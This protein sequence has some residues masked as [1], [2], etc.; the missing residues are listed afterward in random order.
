MDSGPIKV[1]PSILAGDFGHLAD[2]ARRIEDSGAD[3]LHIDIMDGNF[4]PNLTLG[5]KAITAINR[6][7]SMFLD[8]HIMVYHPFDNIER[9]VESGADNITFHFEATEDVEDTLHYIRKC[10]IKAG[11]AFRPETP[12]GM[13]LKYL[14]M[15]D[16]ILMMTVDPGFGG[17]QFIPDVLEKVREIR[18]ICNKLNIRE[19]GVTP[20]SGSK[21]EKLPPLD[22]QVDGGVN[23][24]T[25]RQAIEA[26]ANVLVAGSYLFNCSN[27]AEGIRQLRQAASTVPNEG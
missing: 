2:E 9:I 14:N 19:G 20:Q 22:I 4:V 25:A 26:G 18:D 17:Q 27:M 21:G 6:A 11:L 13:V 5:P 8:V 16:V 12:A 15:C 3:W 7:T 1:A 10:N 24:T 23:P